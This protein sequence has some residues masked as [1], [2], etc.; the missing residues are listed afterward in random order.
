MIGRAKAR[1]EF[2]TEREQS[3]I[4]AGSYEPVRV[5]VDTDPYDVAR[6]RNK[7]QPTP[8]RVL[9]HRQSTGATA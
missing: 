2:V 6:Y 1:R 7:R 3:V 5:L 4:S 8:A 9:S